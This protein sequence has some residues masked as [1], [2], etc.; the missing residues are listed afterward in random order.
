MTRPIDFSRHTVAARA[1][2]LGGAAIAPAAALAARFGQ[3]P[4]NGTYRATLTL[5]AGALLL[6]LDVTALAVWNSATAVLSM[7]D[8]DDPAGLLADFDLTTESGAVSTPLGGYDPAA[9][10]FTAIVTQTGGGSA[11]TTLL[12]LHYVVPPLIEATKT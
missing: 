4:G 7:G 1:L 6:G 11:G 9:H 12:A 8:D 5:P 2:R 3:S 10:T